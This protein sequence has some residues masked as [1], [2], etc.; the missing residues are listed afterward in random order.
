MEKRQRV[1]LYG[2]SLILETVGAS[3]RKYPQFEITSLSAPYPSARQLEA[4]E[5]DV[6]LFDMGTPRP[7]AAFSLLATCPGLQ[8]IGIDPETH[9]TLVWSGRQEPAVVAADLINII[10]PAAD[11]S[12]P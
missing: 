2:D 7:E 10:R 4:M 8:L 11:N 1:V 6:I 3:L 5:P 9:Q 12:P